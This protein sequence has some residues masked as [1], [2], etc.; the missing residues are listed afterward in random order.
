M[1]APNLQRLLEVGQG[2]LS[3]A[4]QDLHPRDLVE[5][6]RDTALLPELAPDGQRFLVVAQRFFGLVQHPIGHRQ[7]VQ[8]GGLLL[9]II[10]LNR[11]G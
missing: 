1:L 8:G 4:E 11:E 6:G 10:Q 2:I 9:L 7:C 3:L 5:A